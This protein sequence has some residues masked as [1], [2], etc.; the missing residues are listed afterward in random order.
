M[1]TCENKLY[2]NCY[3]CASLLDRVVTILCKIYI[4]FS[5]RWLNAEVQVKNFKS[6]AY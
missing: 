6:I 5:G 4:Y 2:D 3:K 1:K